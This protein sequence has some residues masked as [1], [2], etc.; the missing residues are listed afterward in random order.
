MCYSCVVFLNSIGRR[1]FGE[2]L[3]LTRGV[4]LRKILKSCILLC[5][6]TIVYLFIDNLEIDYNV[7]DLLSGIE[8]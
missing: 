3:G 5:V 8:N 1:N 6:Y 7:L 4:T 2:F